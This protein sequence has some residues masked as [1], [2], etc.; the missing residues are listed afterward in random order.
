MNGALNLEIKKYLREHNLKKSDFVRRLG[1]RNLSRGLRNLDRLMQIGIP[2]AFQ[3]ERLGSVLELPEARYQELL[4]AQ[5][6]Q[7]RQACVQKQREEFK[8]YIHVLTEETRPICPIFVACFLGIPSL[9]FP[10]IPEELIAGEDYEVFE[11][12]QHFVR[13]HFAQLGGEVRYMGKITGFIAYIDFDD[14]GRNLRLDSAGNILNTGLK[15]PRSYPE[16]GIYI[17]RRKM[18]ASLLKGGQ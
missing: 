4:I 2:N 18:P 15:A 8:P 7:V 17:K 1:Y 14:P 5:E 3:V 12:V 6:R 11:N 10:R 9:K 16:T 13:Q